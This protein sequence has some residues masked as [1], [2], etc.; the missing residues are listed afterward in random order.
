MS[1]AGNDPANGAAGSQVQGPAI[2]PPFPETA[3]QDGPCRG[4]Q[5]PICKKLAELAKKPW[6]PDEIEDLLN[7]ENFN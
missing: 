1:A 6:L 4:H 2:R 3:R 5:R 7:E